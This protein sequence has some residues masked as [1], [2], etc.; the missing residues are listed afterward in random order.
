[1][2]LTPEQKARIEKNRLAALEKKRKRQSS[3][4]TSL[5]SSSQ[6]LS[7]ESATSIGSTVSSA[8]KERV[9]IN[10]YGQPTPFKNRPDRDDKHFDQFSQESHDSAVKLRREQ[11]LLLLPPLPDEP[12][13]RESTIHSLS[14]Q[15]LEVVQLA[16]P[17]TVHCSN[18]KNCHN[19]NDNDTQQKPGYTVRVTAAAG[20]GKTTTLL[21]LAVRCLDLGH[22]NVT[23][24]TFARASATDAK[25]RIL[26][27]IKTHSVGS[28]DGKGGSS[29]H[30]ITASTLHAC[31]M[32]LV[33]NDED[34]TEKGLTDDSGIQHIIERVY[35]E[36]IKKYLGPA[37][38]RIKASSSSA[39]N[40]NSTEGSSKDT[41][42]G[43]K[44]LM[45]KERAM[46]EQVVY[47]LKK[48]FL[49]FL[50]GTMTLEQY[51]NE[52]NYLRHWYPGKWDC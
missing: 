46:R 33:N 11:E 27:I 22:E 1:M 43:F 18:E 32:Q 34:D 2:A 48:S 15:Q 17:P 42:R 52:R 45:Q 47:Y 28:A 7:Q 49:H 40:G 5:A 6:A 37:L 36:D 8:N 3:G 13:I 4:D 26:E 24:V 29:E 31:A 9:I 10:P 23:Y 30:R 44:T 19:S 21:H 35:A 16:R 14:Q 20:T 51:Q 39:P 12:K 50:H 38:D 25:K 41:Q